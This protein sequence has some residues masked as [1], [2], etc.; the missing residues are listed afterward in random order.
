MV[1]KLSGGIFAQVASYVHSIIFFTI[2][3]Q[4]VELGSADNTILIGYKQSFSLSLAC[5]SIP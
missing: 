5:R 3:V 4:D 1:C 2:G